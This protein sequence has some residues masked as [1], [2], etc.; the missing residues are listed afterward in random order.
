[1]VGGLLGDLVVGAVLG[2]GEWGMGGCQFIWDWDNGWVCGTGVL[3]LGCG[4]AI[5]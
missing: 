3:G 4:V 1:M 5:G 2:W